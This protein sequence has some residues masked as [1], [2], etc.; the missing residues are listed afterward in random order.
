MLS[1]NLAK[2]VLRVTKLRLKKK[3]KKSPELEDMNL[4]AY[5]VKMSCTPQRS[6]H[7]GTSFEL[8]IYFTMSI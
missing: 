6:F 2:I 7:N 3:K 4:E 5:V 1:R 8:F